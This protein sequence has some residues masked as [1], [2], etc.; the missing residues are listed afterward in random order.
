MEEERNDAHCHAASNHGDTGTAGGD[1]AINPDIAM[2]NHQCFHQRFSAGSVLS[3]MS[4]LADSEAFISI[5]F[6]FL[7]F[8]VSIIVV[9]WHGYH[10]LHNLIL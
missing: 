9:L 7:L 8:P 10:D 4:S 5:M 2:N 1:T 6:F 3:S